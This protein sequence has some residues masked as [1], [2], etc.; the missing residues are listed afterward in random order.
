MSKYHFS[1]VVSQDHLF[2]YLSMVSSLRANHNDF[3]VYTLCVNDIVWHILNRINIE[4]IVPVMLKDIESDMIV[5]IKNERPVQAFC[6]TLKPVFL[7]YVMEK[8]PDC[9]YF[10]HLDAVLFFF[11]SP[12]S[13]F[14]E[15]PTASLFLTHHRNSRDFL[16]YYGSTGVFN[17]GFVGCKNDVNAMDAVTKWRTQC[18]L[19][20]P[21]NEDKAR[22]L[23]GDQRYVES[24]PEEF[25]GVHVVSSKGA[26]AA[27]W[28]IQNYNVTEKEGKIFVDEYP[29]IFYH[30]SGMT[31][32][33]RKE[34]NLNWY[35]HIDDKNVLKYIYEP[36]INTLMNIMNEMQRYF[37][38]FIAGFLPKECSPDTHY[39]NAGT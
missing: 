7:H 37:P 27:L 16:K 29:L 31:I 23:F 4:E 10:A 24:W 30:F 9:K 26:N 38:W 36:Y 2:K 20:C 25:R 12:D 13:I 11:S 35:Y 15:N 8:Y 33:S 18:I 32:I 39:Y 5:R 6:W 34:F 3:K 21:I 1:T 17:T 14:L 22:K 19:Y 28:N